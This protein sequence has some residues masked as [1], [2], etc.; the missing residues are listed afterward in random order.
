MERNILLDNFAPLNVRQAIRFPLVGKRP[1]PPKN[2]DGCFRL[3][4]KGRQAMRRSAQKEMPQA[5]SHDT[6]CGIVFIAPATVRP[7][8]FLLHAPAVQRQSGASCPHSSSW[9]PALAPA[10]S[11]DDMRSIPLDIQLGYFDP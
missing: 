10:A 7:G 6:A 11:S 3:P 8:A 1:N 5:V 9:F 4:S 2:P